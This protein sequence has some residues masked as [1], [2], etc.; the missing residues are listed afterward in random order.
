M[1]AEVIGANDVGILVGEDLGDSEIINS[2]ASGTVLALGSRAGG[3]VGIHRGGIS[4]SYANVFARVVGDKVGGLA[5][6]LLGG[7]IR[8]SYA[9]GTVD[10]VNAGGLVGYIEAVTVANSYATASISGRGG[11]GLVSIV[12]G[13]DTS[14][15]TNSYAVGVNDSING[16]GLANEQRTGLLRV[17]A[18]YWDKETSGQTTSAG[19]TSKTTAELQSSTNE[20]YNGWSPLVWD[21][22]TNE[23]YPTLKYATFAATPDRPATCRIATNTSSRL[24]ICGELLP[25]QYTGLTDLVFSDEALQ[26]IPPFNPIIY[27]YKLILK[28]SETQFHTTPTYTGAAYRLFTDNNDRGEV[29]SGVASP[30]ID[31]SRIGGSTTIRLEN[32][33]GI[34]YTIAVS[35]HPY[36]TISD[37][38]V[39]DD[40]L[41]E[42]RNRTDLNAMRYQA[43]GSG[44]RATTA[45]EKI[46]VGCAPTGCIGYE[47]ASSITLSGRNWQ[48]I[49]RHDCS[50]T[51]SQCFTAIFDG[52]RALGYE[53]SGLSID[54]PQQDD[55]G[56]FAHLPAVAEVHN[57][58]VSDVLVVGREG[59]GALVGNNA[60]TVRNIGIAGEVVGHSRVGGL[61]G[62]N[63]GLIDGSFADVVVLGSATGGG[64]IGGLV[65]D[66]TSRI[67]NSSAIGRV[68]GDNDVGGLVGVNHI[69]SE[70]E[71]LIINSYASVLVSGDSAL[72]GLVGHNAPGARV[73]ASYAL[74]EVSGNN[75]V[76]GLVGLNFGRLL[77]TYASGSVSAQRLV[78]GLVGRNEQ[79]GKI[80]A[81]Y[82]IGQ[83]NDVNEAGGLVGSSIRGISDSY[84]DK[85][86][87]G[88]TTSA[89]GTSQTTTQLQTPTSATG[90]YVN[91]K[92]DNWDFGT[93]AQY[94]QLK[95][96]RGTDKDNRACG[97]IGQ[98]ACFTRQHYGLSNLE[99]IGDA[100]LISPFTTARLHYRIEAYF[101]A[102]KSLR[103]RPTATDSSATITIVYN[104]RRTN[105]ASGANSA[106]IMLDPTV[107]DVIVVSVNNGGHIVEYMLEID[108]L[109]VVDRTLADA[110]GDGLIEIET[111]ED[112]NAIRRVPRGNVYI[113][114]RLLPSD[115][116]LRTTAGCPSTG[117]RGYELVRDLDFNDDR[118]YSSISNKITWAVNDF[119]DAS[120]T[121]WI[122]VDLNA[123]FDGNGHTI[124]NLQINNRS[125][126]NVGLFGSIRESGTVQNLTLRN[127]RIRGSRTAG[128]FVGGLA[129]ENQGVILNSG[130]IN[131][132]IE[133][134]SSS[135]QNTPNLVGG[136]VGRNNGD[137]S[138]IGNIRYSFVHGD[139]RVR[140]TTTA[141]S[142]SVGGL[143][144]ENINGAG[145]YNSYAVG[146]VTACQRFGGLVGTQTS[147]EQ[148]SSVVRE[149]YTVA[150]LKVWDNCSQTN[151]R[152]RLVGINT[153]SYIVNSYAV[154][155]SPVD[156]AI[157]L[158]HQGVGSQISDIRVSY[159]YNNT[160]FITLRGR[161]KADLQQVT[162]RTGIYY[163][164]NTSDW[165]FG[166]TE[167]YPTLRAAD[168]SLAEQIWDN[169][170][171]DRIDVEN[172]AITDLNGDTDFG[173]NGFNYNYRYRLYVD[174]NQ[175]SLPI[176]FTT[177]P[178][179]GLET[180]LYCDGVR[181]PLA[182]DGHAIILGTTN[183]QVIRLQ[184]RKNNRIMEYY[185][186]VIYESLNLNNV[187]AIDINEGDTFT[188]T[189]DYA[190]SG[191][192]SWSQIE[193]PRIDVS[194]TDSLNLK[195]MPQA[196]LVPKGSDYSIVKYRLEAGIGDQTY[197]VREI[198]ARINKVN[199]GLIRGNIT[200]MPTNNTITLS[201]N[202]SDVDGMLTIENRQ[203]QRRS[204]IGNWV[205]IDLVRSG[206]TYTVPSEGIGYQYRLIAYY[207]DGQGYPESIISTVAGVPASSISLDIDGDLISNAEDI[208]D[209]NDGLIE[210]E[211]LEDLNAIRYQLDGGSYKS[212]ADAEP[213]T[214]GCPDTGCVGYELI[215]NLDFDDTASYRSGALNP[216][217]RVAGGNF[218][219]QNDVGWQP[220]GGAFN[221]VFNGNNHTISHLT[222]NRSVDDLGNVGLFS[223]IAKDGKVEN[224]GLIN[225][226][227]NGLVGHKNV[228]S[229]AGMVHQG[230]VI[231]NSYATGSSAD[232]AVVYA[233]HSDRGLLGGL[234][235][236]N[237]GYILNSHA[238]INVSVQDSDFDISNNGNVNVGGLVGRNRSGG[239]IHN[240]YYASGEVR[241]SCIAG[242]L[243]GSQQSVSNQSDAVTEIRNS[244]VWNDSR[245]TVLSIA[246]CANPYVGGLVGVHLNGK[247]IIAHSYAG[248]RAYAPLHFIGR[249]LQ[250]ADIGSIG[251][252][253]VAVCR[254]D[255]IMPID[256]RNQV[257]VAGLLS[258]NS[259][260]DRL[261]VN[262]YWRREPYRCAVT[263]FVNTYLRHAVTQDD[264]DNRR[265]NSRLTNPVTPNASQVCLI[266]VDTMN[267]T[268]QTATSD[269]STYNRWNTGDW[270]FG[271][272][273]QYALLRYSEG[274]DRNDPACDFDDSTRLPRCGAL[275]AGQP[276][277]QPVS[278]RST[279]TV[280]N[281]P[282]QVVIEYAR[283]GSTSTL[284]SMQDTII[285]NEGD[286]LTLDAANSFAA[287][288]AALVYNWKQTSG[289]QLLSSAKTKPVLRLNVQDDLFTA[290]TDRGQAIIRLELVKRD[291]RSAFVH[292]DITIN[293]IR[294]NRRGKITLDWVNTLL[295]ASP[296]NDAD[297]APYTHVVYQWQREVNGN[298]V[299]IV[300][301]TSATY[302][303]SADATDSRYF[304]RTTYVDRQ[305]Y[306]NTIVSVAPPYSAVRQVDR[307]RDGLI[308]IFFIEQ[309]DAIR[310][311]PDGTG[312]KASTA[313][314]V[315][316][317]GCPDNV[318]RGYE[319]TRDLDF[320]NP[321]SY[322]TS[323]DVTA[324]WNN[325]DPIDNFNTVLEGNGHTIFNLSIATTVSNRVTV[326][327]RN[328]GLFARISGSKAEIRRVRLAKVNIAGSDNV[329]A[330]VGVFQGVRIN[331]S[332]ILSGTIQTY[333]KGGCLVGINRGS[334]SDSSADCALSGNR[335]LGGLV[336]ESFAM[337]SNSSATGTITLRDSDITFNSEVAHG[338]L[339]GFNHGR[340]ENS[341]ST[342]SIEQ[343]GIGST[344]P[345]FGIGG[346]VGVGQ[347]FTSIK[348]SY[349]TGNIAGDNAS[350]IGGLIGFSG[351]SIDDSYATGD[352]SGGDRVG[353]LVGVSLRGA[354]GNSYATGDVSGVNEVGGLIGR[355]GPEAVHDSYASGN[356]SGGDRVG[357]LV[358]QVG[359]IIE[360]F[361]F[362]IRGQ[363]QNSFAIGT[364]TGNGNV[365]GLAGLVFGEIS[366]SHAIGRV[367]IKDY[368]DS[369]RGNGG[370]V[371]QLHG[372][373]TA[374]NNS[375]ALGS[376]DSQ[377]CTSLNC[378][379]HG[380]LVGILDSLSKDINNS[381]AAVSLEGSATRKGGLVG[382]TKDGISINNS[383]SISKVSGRSSDRGFVQETLGSHN[384]QHSYW[385]TER[386]G[387]TLGG[388]D[389]ALGFDSQT[390]KST[391]PSTNTHPYLNWS[392]SHW[393]FGNI[394]QYPALKYHDSTCD[395]ATPSANCENILPRQ[396]LGL[397]GLQLSQ[398]DMEIQPKISPAFRG[399]VLK[400]DF[401]NVAV[402]NYAVSL[403]GGVSKIH[404]AAAAQNPE[405]IITINGSPMLVGSAN[406]FFV[407]DFSTA[408]VVRI[409][410]SEPYQIAG[411]ENLD[412]EYR[413]TFT[414]STFP[415]ASAI[416]I[417]AAEDEH[418]E[419]LS[420]SVPIR[421]GHFITLNSALSDIDGD[422]LSYEWVVDETQVRLLDR[423]VL[424][425]SVAGGSGNATL[426]FYLR[427]DFIPADQTAET[428]SASLTVRDDDGKTAAR[429]LSFVV[430]KHDNDVI[431]DI[432]T[433]T[434]IGFT[435]IAPLLDSA[436]L[437]EDS[438]GTGN[439]NTIRYQWQRQS[440]GNWFD[441]VGANARSYTV[442]GKIAYYYRVIVSY[443]DGQGYR[444][445]IVSAPLFTSVE[446]VREASSASEGDGFDILVLDADG[447]MP[448]FMPTLTRYRVPAETNSIKVTAVARGG[449]RFINDIPLSE[450]QRSLTVDLDYGDNEIVAVWRGT[451]SNSTQNYTVFRA[452]DIGLHS[453]GVAWQDENGELQS[454]D[455]SGSNLEPNPSPR[456]PNSVPIT[457]TARV[458]ELVDIAIASSGNTV[459]KITT[460]TQAGL[461]IAQATISDLALGANRVDF[462]VTSPDHSSAT[463]AV[464]VWHRYNSRLRDLS[465]EDGL[466]TSA[467]EITMFDPLRFDYKTMIPNRRDSITIEFQRNDR[468]TIV[469][470]D[471][472]I[473]DDDTTK[474]IDGLDIGD[475][476]IITAVSAPGELDTTYQIIVTRNHDL[477]LRSL[478][479]MDSQMTPVTLLPTFASTQH[480][481][482]AQVPNTTTQVIVTFATDL[483]VE[484]N[485]GAHTIPTLIRQRIHN[486]DRIE[487]TIL[488]PLDVGENLI[489]IRT[490][491]LGGQ[492]AT[493]LTITRLKSSD[494]RLHR[495]ELLPTTG[496][497]VVIFD[498]PNET[499]EHEREFDFEIAGVMVIP[500]IHSDADKVEVFAPGSSIGEEIGSTGRSSVIALTVGEPAEIRILVT[501]QDQTTRDYVIRVTRTLS[502]N[503]LL[504]VLEVS[505]G[506][507]TP[508]FI[509]DPSQEENP[510]IHYSAE[511]PD[512]IANTTM[513]VTAANAHARL[514]IREANNSPSSPHHSLRQAI[515]I[516]AGSHTTFTIMVTAQNGSTRTYTVTLSRASAMDRDA[517]GLML[518][519]TNID[520][521]NESETIY[522]GRLLN[523]STNTMASAAVT[524]VDVSIQSIRVGNTNYILNGD[525]INLSASAPAIPVSRVIPLARQKNQIT[526]VVRRT[527][528]TEDGYT[529]ANYI[530]NILI[531]R[532]QL[533]VFLEGLMR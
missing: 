75:G 160:P 82:A 302:M 65:G 106:P 400:D 217:W 528:N 19:G 209:D 440:G 25:E 526:F 314:T 345:F 458:N 449:E 375:Y 280:S 119:D 405:G 471:K 259:D 264:L 84:W 107:D 249:S 54:L 406:Y 389:D 358:G 57:L 194:G 243:V 320:D 121:G 417:S 144:G 509:F 402:E 443:R 62:D 344:D 118:S 13:T 525:P 293:L 171:V 150:N 91:W 162:T 480:E 176:T 5:G 43:D 451:N 269:C 516:D 166:T 205:D 511:L 377:A 206:S 244:Y 333:H 457:V 174:G 70:S 501:A 499:S 412:V 472:T 273:T 306:V 36:L 478:S 329:G 274:A 203:F 212:S 296:I 496:S 419:P 299:D 14:A 270:D 48:P 343:S 16:R 285:L 8:W 286:T 202:P 435:Y 275:L 281:I 532:I 445:S 69:V 116:E 479:L 204:L 126:N 456:V 510:Q 495:L 483:Q 502:R 163:T 2:H 340:I 187:S 229:I 508:P 102:T 232:G 497:A 294:T 422:D 519:L 158:T 263:D 342:I 164:W 173:E 437:M 353:G 87:S 298:R 167:Q 184:V 311:Q 37:V 364:V 372:S 83:V 265:S 420:I 278:P 459:G 527:D 326:D 231:R 228:G 287:D 355:S 432:S 115:T 227:I 72:G 430:D 7:N 125:Q 260:T 139:I 413:L 426:S 475:N 17:F 315:H 448:I 145:V 398:F 395:T 513:T 117:C 198:L 130:V 271:T 427:E 371:G 223:E 460:S 382:Q 147:L 235:G 530:V 218:R 492:Q 350:N 178:T 486:N 207:T 428:V 224:L 385:D 288:N 132:D 137:G 482:T 239:K 81:S 154:V 245:V 222:I 161:T 31:A 354:I 129:A 143:V 312:Y 22:G 155:E 373:R 341:H 131:A 78:G 401:N 276:R 310:H 179:V 415:E 317:T 308:D 156:L 487:K 277:F 112:L 366:N 233:I 477:A 241:S 409:L 359:V 297:G 488:L 258:Y 88:Q 374:I 11:G 196:D 76:G 462:V 494:S 279:P 506:E 444:N 295:F 309:L 170:L 33:E 105:V 283:N 442:D 53:I 80:R 250:V 26:L 30:R 172:A 300:G 191:N 397:R 403:G 338:G 515:A 201:E 339:V 301:A 334:I 185:F 423:T 396:R 77:N 507:L 157:G 328:L 394:E 97:G 104:G 284:L 387:Q 47:L 24:P 21:F 441:I 365:G 290:D 148:R 454:E 153:L 450:D 522:I 200:L 467:G 455:F 60:G 512:D 267:D 303:V 12:G 383:Y 103:L 242:G 27:D 49:G 446:I 248:G 23:Q 332:H 436:K 268:E 500:T 253:S 247:S 42:I 529:E 73:W 255:E 323:S 4:N 313:A 94:P 367:V 213:N 51:N 439:P 504:S 319:L 181:C 363:I 347:V 40:G 318:C 429:E 376:V 226:T 414:F 493:T 464:N 466:R 257:S 50:R 524:T 110:D 336:G 44:Y 74:G 390:L 335:I 133:G 190:G 411:K 393:D 159:W 32:S 141:S 356:V 407:A 46:T 368:S 151:G 90:I 28:A 238:Q 292:K 416:A 138:L 262:S 381:Y 29:Q 35:H 79:D 135:V 327:N 370:L 378:G 211:F 152:G 463:H 34:V 3:L 92:S 252:V 216:D 325:W 533:R 453:W 349:A 425:G 188:I 101:G 58:S 291:N 380:G 469:I 424:N 392:I 134:V 215:K 6:S 251:K 149:S 357:G 142:H 316:T 18:S 169:V 321:D 256:N 120:D 272:N 177:T 324:Q 61:V 404:I 485:L 348:N 127:L 140:E 282:P 399:A 330:L 523:M 195:L 56:L 146:S 214:S 489:T 362:Y 168:G 55:V 109:S 386:S 514:T 433:P 221:A 189:G 438:D 369:S 304:L 476:D 337:I 408:T 498:V 67:F 452:Y 15:I 122:P 165:D 38:D 20:I 182:A 199:N 517:L 197:I 100:R 108:Y 39:D 219:D 52:N 208:D 124:S 352:V 68:S 123:L 175:L 521:K 180:T 503:N 85:E 41:I 447:L 66:N 193:G 96:A 86:T 484:S 10:G 434:Q 410:V 473:P 59:V 237:E 379:R 490:S 236:V 64:G 93:A 192:I 322:S 470:N 520:L 266:G 183:T 254:N 531:L 361:N 1:D 98:P 136:L 384:I 220:I 331:D 45:T 9:G 128:Q 346:L 468:S 474:M 431:D 111:L 465:I 461:L 230:G 491:A 210:I 307:D 246:S 71:G 99:I 261:P 89:G 225:P 63:D 505:S 360:S 305:G 240:S 289:R 518:D 95:Y 186:D 114:P 388:V 391:T 351:S 481:Y 113:Y 234:V 418:T 421:E